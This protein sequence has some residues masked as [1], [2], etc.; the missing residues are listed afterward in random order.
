VLEES[1]R[2][3]EDGNG[4]RQEENRYRQ[5]SAGAHDVIVDAAEPTASRFVAMSDQTVVSA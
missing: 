4:Q 3:P 1:G 5:S 2:K